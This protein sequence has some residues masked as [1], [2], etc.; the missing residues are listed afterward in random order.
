MA[1]VYLEFRAGLLVGSGPAQVEPWRARV[2][3]TGSAQWGRVH[4]GAGDLQLIQ[5]G[6]VIFVPGKSLVNWV[7]VKINP[8]KNRRVLVFGFI[9][10]GSILGTH[11]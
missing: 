10:Q 5:M 9:Y 8:P 3:A 4:R 1:N 6:E 7:W 11:F 2:R